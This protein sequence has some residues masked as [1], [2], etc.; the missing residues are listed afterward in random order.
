MQEDLALLVAFPQVLVFNP[1][2]I[3]LSVRS[4]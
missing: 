2:L 1:Q 4:L 3:G